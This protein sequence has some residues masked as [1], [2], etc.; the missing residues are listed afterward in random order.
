MPRIGE[1]RISIRRLAYI[2]AIFILFS[3]GSFYLAMQNSLLLDELFCTLI[4]DMVFLGIFVI[5]IMQGRT[6]GRLSY[7]GTSYSR[8]FLLLVVGWVLAIIGSMLSDFLMPIGFLTFWFSSYLTEALT[9]E[10]GLYFVTM[11]C[12]LCGR[13]T[14]SIYNYCLL[15]ALNV[16][17]AGYLREIRHQKTLSKALFV[18]MIGMV[19]AF[20]PIVFYYFNFGKLDNVIVEEVCLEAVLLMLFAWFLYPKLTD[21]QEQ[22][23]QVSY[24]LLLEDDYPLLQ[25]LKR[26]SEAEYRHAKRVSELSVVC[27]R[28]IGAD[29]NTL[30]AAGLYYRL[31]KME[32]APEID[33]AVRLAIN[34][35]FPPEVIAI[36]EEFEGEKRLPQSPES[37]IV[38]MVNALVT[39]IELMDSDTM[40]SSWNEDMLIYQTLNEFSNTGVYDQS[41]LSMNQFLKIRE[42]LAQEYMLQSR[43]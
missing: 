42:K 7:Q 20:L 38:H 12:L 6:T 22:E 9:L 25:D 32:G 1:P 21:F 2:V 37:A 34:R 5:A 23:R 19:N 29:E 8:L 4:I 41:G 18:C 26:Y 3:C 31:G 13:G 40:Q 33:N 27:G 10:A 30:A 16:L 43:R 36:L 28:E 35:C 11:V 17:L 39:R 14:Y 24:D 15:L